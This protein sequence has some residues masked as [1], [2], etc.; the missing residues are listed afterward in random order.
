M[1]KLIA[2][3]L[4]VNKILLLEHKYRNEINSKTGLSLL[5]RDQL[6]TKDA[7][8]E[9]TTHFF[10]RPFSFP[11]GYGFLHSVDEIFG[12]D[13]YKFS[14]ETD[15]PYIIDCGANMGLSIYYF[16]KIF[17]N[18]KILAFEP[19]NHIFKLLEKNIKHFPNNTQ[20]ELKKEA[21]WTEDTYLNFFS[22]GSLAGS[23]TVD[24]SNNQNTYQTKAVDLKKYL[25]EKVNFLKIDIEGAE[26]EVIFDI[27]NHLQNVENLFLEFHGLSG[28]PQNLNKILDVL[29]NQGFQYYI[30]NAD[31]VMKHPF[32]DKIPRPFNQQ[33]NIFCFRA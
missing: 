21:V 17:P 25:N 15:S 29:T 19:D 27:Q 8:Q 33:L 16:K 5:Q 26:N 12:E 20:I 18:A 23:C 6:C 3:F 10:G 9:G 24:F 2:E 30:K 28:K 14:S 4:K 1:K 7:F 13:I 22:E 31:D 11:T 32:Y